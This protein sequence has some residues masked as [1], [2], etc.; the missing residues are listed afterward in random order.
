MIRERDRRVSERPH[1]NPLIS[2]NYLVYQ[3]L[4]KRKMIVS[5][6][7]FHAKRKTKAREKYSDQRAKASNCSLTQSR[8]S[9]S[10]NSY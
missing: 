1:E 9:L 2:M 4:I 5:R 10:S 6:K 7:N 8:A 3:K